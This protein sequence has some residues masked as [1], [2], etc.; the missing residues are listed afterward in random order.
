L[1]AG[2]FLG[3]RLL[4]V[5]ASGQ[6]L[7]ERPGAGTFLGQVGF[8][9]FGVFFGFHIPLWLSFS[10]CRFLCLETGVLIRL[11]FD[12]FLRWALSL[13]LSRFACR[14]TPGLFLGTEAGEAISSVQ[15]TSQ[16]FDFACDLCHATTF[17][18]FPCRCD[19]RL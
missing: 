5:P 11:A 9:P 18:C 16:L 7:L 6:L 3:Q 8:G 12:G 15:R 14:V 13:S 2:T 19:P 10:R 4:L 17:F 1:G